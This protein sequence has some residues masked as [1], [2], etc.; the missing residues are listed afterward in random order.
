VSCAW[1]VG[2]AEEDVVRHNKKAFAAQP[3]RLLVRAVDLEEAGPGQPHLS[4]TLGA[5][6]FQFP[7]DDSKKPRSQDMPGFVLF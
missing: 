2:C 1:K 5:L 4:L 3:A 7:H 6:K